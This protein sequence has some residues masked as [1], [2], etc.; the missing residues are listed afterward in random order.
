MT[1]LYK[2]E[3][4]ECLYVIKFSKHPSLFKIGISVNINNRLIQLK[5]DH[6]EVQSISVYYGSNAKYVERILH[7]TFKNFRVRVSGQGGTEFFK[8]HI[9]FDTLENACASCGLERREPV[10][11]LKNKASKIKKAKEDFSK[12]FNTTERPLYFQHLIDY[13]KRVGECFVIVGENTWSVNL[14]SSNTLSVVNR[15]QSRVLCVNEDVDL[16]WLR[17]NC[18]IIRFWDEY[19]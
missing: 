18:N 6:G 4:G 8:E 5:G 16:L 1:K 14:V 12:G 7:N 19:C 10:F 11:T 13:I 17:N 9:S 15:H 3:C 2:Y